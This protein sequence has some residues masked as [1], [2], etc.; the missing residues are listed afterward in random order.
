MIKQKVDLNLLVTSVLK[1]FE[2]EKQGRDI[3]FNILP[4]PEVRADSSMIR[5]VY[6]NLISN[7]I[8]YT[9]KKEHALIKAGF[10]EDKKE[11][12]LYIQDN[13]VGFEMEYVS[14][15]FKVFRRLHSEKDYKGTG[16][17][18][19]IVRQIVKRHGGK[20]WA[21]GEPDKGAI[22]YFTI[23]KNEEDYE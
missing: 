2:V 8:K 9:S 14:R 12:I 1:D 13:G 3:S 19:A 16:I 15:L 21:E 22:F 6:V 7:A 11:Y 5:M 18:L 20:T 4:L 10:G 17:G 23:P